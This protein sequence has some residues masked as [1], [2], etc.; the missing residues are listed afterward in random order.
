MT[1]AA[2]GAGVAGYNWGMNVPTEMPTLPQVSLPQVSLPQVNLPQVSLPHPDLS[3]V[4]DALPDSVSDKLTEILPERL[5]G[6]SGPSKWWLVAGAVA[7]GAG[8][9]WWM[10]RRRENAEA[11]AGGTAR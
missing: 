3:G 8:L 5:T 7:A 9:A 11:P 2:H 1:P 4:V 6:D 10:R